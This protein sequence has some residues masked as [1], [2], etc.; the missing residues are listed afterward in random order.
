MISYVFD[1][2]ES[3]YWYLTVYHPAEE[4]GVA[5]ESFKVCPDDVQKVDRA[6]A[7][8]FDDLSAQV[9]YASASG[10][11]VQGLI[12]AIT[13][14]IAASPALVEAWAGAG[15]AA[16]VDAAETTAITT[17]YGIEAQSASADAQAGLSLAQDG[18]TLYRSGTLGD[19]MTS[20]SQYWSLDNPASTPDYNAQMGTPEP[21]VGEPFMM[22]GTLN[23]GA[24]V[25]TNE[26]G[27]LGSNAGGGIQVVVSPNGV[28]IDWFHMP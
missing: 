24:D 19:N 28:G 3:A 9:N 5:T 27:G 21:G 6:M 26:A 1:L 11:E 2:Q 16:E 4:V 10:T 12:N 17:P 13:A 8:I 22:G 7:G 20:E 15:A 25:I 14:A 23:S 18:A